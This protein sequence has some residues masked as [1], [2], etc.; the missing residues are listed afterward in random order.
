MKATQGFKEHGDQEPYNGTSTLR[1]YTPLSLV[2]LYSLVS[3]TPLRLC[4][5]FAWS[6]VPFTGSGALRGVSR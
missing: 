5:A 4:I 2:V 3:P 1:S 6:F